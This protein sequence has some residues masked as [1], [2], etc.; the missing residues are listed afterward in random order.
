MLQRQLNHGWQVAGT[1]FG[2]LLLYSGAFLL[3]LIVAPALRLVLPQK[4]S[5]Q[6]MRQAIYRACQFYIFILES[7]GLASIEWINLDSYPAERPLLLIA[8]H[9]TLLDVVIILA[10]IPAINLVAKDNLWNNAVFSGILHSIGAIRNG[11]DQDPQLFIQQC[12]DCISAGD[13]LLIFP[14]GTRSTPGKLNKFSRAPAAI[15]LKTGSL[16][17]P[18][19]IVSKPAILTKQHPWYNN[20]AHKASIRLH[21]LEPLAIRQMQPRYANPYIARRELTEKISN[22][23]L[24]K[25]RNEDS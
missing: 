17:V 4:R 19:C 2:L 7:L 6:T 1:A 14:E 25:L 8:N 3:S 12:A 18:I 9:P 5:R 21:I 11:K 20:R 22:L 10:K 16:I 13:S 23:F 15:A 24:K